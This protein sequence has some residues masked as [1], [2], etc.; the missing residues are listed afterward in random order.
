[1][2]ADS[3]P[4]WVLCVGVSTAL[5]MLAAATFLAMPPV[6]AGVGPV[7]LVSVDTAIEPMAMD[8]APPA[9]P[10]VPPPERSEP[11]PQEPAPPQPKPPA[12]EARVAKPV[13]APVPEP[14]PPTRVRLGVDDGVK[15]A[16]AW[17][18]STEDGVHQG[19]L[20]ET[21]Q[22]ALA[23]NPGPGGKPAPDS[24]QSAPSPTNP[25]AAPAAPADRP[26]ETR[27]A[28]T[29]AEPSKPPTAEPPA[30]STPPMDAP[31]VERPAG[32]EPTESPA[33][34][35]AA[36]P[37]RVPAPAE[38]APADA[39]QRP[40]TE[41]VAG[42]DQAD[43]PKIPDGVGLGSPQ[44]AQRG[45]AAKPTPMPPEPLPS[46]VRPLRDTNPRRETPTPA[47]P[48]A[49][50]PPNAPSA[51]IWVP[52]PLGP[53]SLSAL[54]PDLTS[55]Q[56]AAPARATPASRAGGGDPNDRGARSDRQSDAASTV[57]R[58]ATYRNGRVDAGEGLDIRTVRPEFSLVARTLTNPRPP[59]MEIVFA[60]D[61][62]VQDVRV[63]ETSGY[64]RDIDD[65]IVAAMYRWRAS[66]KALAELSAAGNGR[67][68]IEITVR[69]GG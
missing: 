58:Q 24:P 61:G 13:P 1:M 4:V 62:T 28:T 54:T 10:V 32:A 41:R 35:A 67:I 19:L 64:A 17:L 34:D 46:P 51:R 5:H 65:R 48:P 20:A 3:R 60:G 63:L 42:T 44:T 16:K 53:M 50:M 39:I 26:P 45:P 9:P 22:A 52:T 66:G 12:P 27:A 37:V 18:R 40:T 21:D 14:P 31:P 33:R 29:P 55:P 68:A 38:R 30:P 23:R 49:P 56:A 43:L 25:G 59:K 69:L 15:G 8:P 57:R 36:A 2:A 6:S 47:P 11:R 7:S